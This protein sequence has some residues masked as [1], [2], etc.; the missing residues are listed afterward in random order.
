MVLICIFLM[1]SDVEHLSMCL[2]G[3][4][5]ILF[6]FVCLI[7]TFNYLDIQHMGLQLKSCLERCKR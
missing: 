6:K 5:Q 4:A 3:V 7:I 1:N 2:L